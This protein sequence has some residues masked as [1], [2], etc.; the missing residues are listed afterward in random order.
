MQTDNDY[1]LVRMWFE[2]DGQRTYYDTPRPAGLVKQFINGLGCPKVKWGYDE[3][4]GN[5]Q[6]LESHPEGEPVSPVPPDL[7]Q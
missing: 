2:V 3:M 6:G 1:R 7:R 5:Q 4:P